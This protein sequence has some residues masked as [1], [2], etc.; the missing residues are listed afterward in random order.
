MT[1]DPSQE[2]IGTPLVA[3]TAKSIILIDCDTPV[4]RSYI[5]Q[6]VRTTVIGKYDDGTAPVLH[7]MVVIVEPRE[8]TGQLTNIDL[9]GNEPHHPAGNRFTVEPYFC[10]IVKTFISRVMELSTL[11]VWK[12]STH[13]QQ[14]SGSRSC[15]PGA[16]HGP[17]DHQK[18]ICDSGPEDL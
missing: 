5:R 7:A 6:G 15:G 4:D 9:G 1:L 2:L 14:H 13:M 16:K 8:I 12:I 17:A 11:A 18:S 3:W 10:L